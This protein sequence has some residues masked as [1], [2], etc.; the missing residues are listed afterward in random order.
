M[1]ITKIK[2]DRIEQLTKEDVGLS[3]AI[4]GSGIIGQIPF[5]NT[6]SSL[7]GD[8]SL[9]WN[10]TN[11]Q[12]LLG[13]A[14]ISQSNSKFQDN[15][16]FILGDQA[17]SGSN[18]F[19]TNISNSTYGYGVWVAHNLQFN[20]VNFIQ[21]RGDILSR[22]FTV[23]Q[24]K[25][26]SFNIGNQ[27]G[28]NG[29]VVTM[30]QVASISSAGI[31]TLAGLVIN[32]LPNGNSDAS[33]TRN[34][35]QKADGTVGWEN[36]A[37]VL[38][39]E[40]GQVKI[41][42]TGLS[43]TGFTTNINKQFNIGAATPSIVASPT[44]KYPNSTPN[45]YAGIFDSTRNAGTSTFSGRLIENP[46][47]GQPHRFRIQGNYNNKNINNVGA[48]DLVLRNPVS[49][50]TSTKSITLPDGRVSGLFD[51]IILVIADSNSVST[52]NGYILEVGTSFNDSNLTIDITSI[53]RFSDAIEP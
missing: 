15:Y 5:Y 16:S 1:A 53:T 37:T 41:N 30:T 11:K 19:H 14:I 36:K 8:T 7:S 49:G 35:I 29:S 46:I 32:N 50:F 43:I 13:T 28:V 20:G 4:T 25:G 42:Y 26:F 17:V 21:P 9:S 10:N 34:I 18:I 24:N 6:T 52:P 22:A 45:N 48:L 31:M 44:T 39:N 23:N 3:N 33:F 51:E 2:K 12:L 40:A 47:L 38:K 27:T